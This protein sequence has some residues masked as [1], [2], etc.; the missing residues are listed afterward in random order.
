MK[1]VI[2]AQIL[3]LSDCHYGIKAQFLSKNIRNNKTI[4][5]ISE[6]WD[7]FGKEDMKIVK[8]KER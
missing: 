2:T 6:D 3:R 5:I 7:V 4:R 8:G 1:R